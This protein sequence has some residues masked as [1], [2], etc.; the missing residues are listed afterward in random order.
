MDTLLKEFRSAARAFEDTLVELRRTL[1]EHPETGWGEFQT[2]STLKHWLV[3]SGLP[4]PVATA[5]TGFYLDIK[6]R[7]DGPLIA[8]RADM[9]ALPIQDQKE[10]SYASKRSGFGHLCG[11]DAHSTIAAGVARLLH[12][13]QDAFTGTVRMIWQP[14]EEV[15]PSGAPRIIEEGVVD[16]VEAIYAAH[17]D[18]G[19]PS[20][21]ISAR[22]G[23]ETG[24]F[25]TFEITVD[26]PSTTHSARPYE[27][28]D[29]IWIAH[30]IIQHLYQMIGRI[31]DARRPAVMSVCAFHA[32]DAL[33]VIPHHVTFGGT[34]RTMSE[35][36]RQ[37]LRGHITETAGA[38]GRMN[39]V[40]VN[41]RYGGGAPSVVNNDQLFRFVRDYVISQLGGERF[42]DREQSL[43]A[44]DFA[45]F[46][47]RIPGM[48][49]RIGTARNRQ[50]SWPL[51]HSLF[52]VDERVLAP[53]S[54]FVAGMLCR[55]LDERL[56]HAK[57]RT[58]TGILHNG[59]PENGKPEVWRKP[60][61]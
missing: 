60:Q 26:A 58:D 55:H 14:A 32:G 8:W 4:T 34:L 31:S 42:A 15:T 40:D 43:G 23:A 50:T 13:H 59:E 22:P 6:G 21:T 17:C 18:P 9:D 3:E 16:R 36:L 27:G 44:E 29:T 33:N 5:Q 24:S 11:H 1:H 41:V 51:H 39:R 56:L 52:D 45:Y 54:A 53:S 20:G 10:V 49:L 30:Q 47:Q 12:E 7:G 61:F 48:F 38:I 35:K 46:T 28:K 25:D 57:L 19:L 37:Q 2:S